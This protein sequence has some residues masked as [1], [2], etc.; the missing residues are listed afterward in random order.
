MTLSQLL[1]EL[2]HRGI[3]LN[4][5]GETLK[6]HGPKANLTPEL[7]N[8]LRQHKQTLLAHLQKSAPIDDALP[9]CKPD[10]E[11]LYKPFPL[12][13]LQQGF[14]VADDPH[15][16]FHVRPHYYME[17]DVEN[18]DVGRYEAAWNKLFQRHRLELAL[19]REDGNLEIIEN[20]E[21]LRVKAIDLRD[22]PL[23]E[24]TQFLAA[25]RAQ[26]MRSELPLDRWPWHDVRVTLWR[27]DDTDYGRIH[28]NHN[29]FFSDGY[30]TARALQEIEQYY[31]DP[32]AVLPPLSLSYRDAVIALDQLAES[33]QGLLA[34]RYWE[35][36]LPLLPGPP[37]LPFRPGMNRRCRS[38]L[39]RREK[40]MDAASWDS[41]KTYARKYGLTYSNAIFAAYAEILA[42]WSN[43]KHFVLSNMMTRRLNIHPEISDILGNFASL[44][45]L[46]I[47]LRT[48]AS[49]LE[50]AHQI[51][52]QVIQDSQHR[53]WGGMQVMQALN[54]LAGGFGRAPIPFVVGSGLFMEGFERYDFGCLETSQVMLDHQF[55]ELPD[56]SYFIVW[57][58]LE[59]FFSDG[60]VDAMWNAYLSLMNGLATDSTMWESKDFN[61]IPLSHLEERNRLN[62]SSH[63]ASSHRLHDFLYTHSNDNPERFAL[64]TS[65]DTLTYRQLHQRA[66]AITAALQA[67]GVCRQD[68]VAVIA[69]RNST[70][71]IALYGIL[72]AG[73]A[74]VPV[75]PSLPEERRQYL[76]NNSQAKLAITQSSYATSM[77][78]PDG[79]PILVADHIDEALAAPLNNDGATGNS[80]AEDLAYIIYTSGST[81]RPKG[82]MIDHR[83]IIN[84]IL[85]INQRFQVGSDDRFLGVSSFGF[86]L[87]VYDIFGAAAA[88]ATLLYPDPDKALNPA[89]WLDVL[90]AQQI[91]IWNSAPALASLLIEVAEYRGVQLESL[92]LVLLSGDWIPL[93][94][95]KRIRNVAPNAQVISLGG[96]TEASIWSIIYPVDH[97]DP[98]WVS[99]PYGYPMKNQSWFVMDEWNRPAPVWVQGDLYIGGTGLAKGYWNNP[100]KTAAAFITSPETGERLY[101]TGDIGRYLPDGSIELLGRKDSQIKIQ[102]HRIE[103]GEIESVLGSHPEIS[104]V[105]VIAQRA[106]TGKSMQL[107][108][109]IVRHADSTIDAETLRRYSANKLPDY[110]VPRLFHF[111]DKLPLNS[112]GKIDRQALS[113]IEESLTAD[114]SH[115]RYT[116]NNAVEAKL[117]EIW[118]R[119]L[120]AKDIS[121]TADFFRLGGQSFEAVRLIGLVK[122]TFGIGL[123]LGDIWRYPTIAQLAE[124]L[125]D[126]HQNTN[127]PLVAIN[128][129]NS[130]IPLFLVHPAAGHVMCYRYLGEQLNRPVY[131]FEALGIDGQHAPRSSVVEMATAYCASLKT[132]H[133]HGPI[134]IGGWSSGGPIAF[135]MA[136]QL[137]REGRTVE[138]IIIIDSPAP[139]IHDNA[140]DS[141]L[142]DWFLEDLMLDAE[143][144]AEIKTRTQHQS[145][146]EE[147]IK[148]LAQ[149]LAEYNTKLAADFDQLTMLYNVFIAVVR[150]NR[151]YRPNSI[152]VDMLIIRA[153]DG[154]VSEFAGYPYVD[155]MDWGWH[156]L[157]SG[158][159]SGEFLPGSHHT[160]LLPP[161]VNTISTMLET[162][163]PIV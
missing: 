62:Q 1:Q 48:G 10:A 162:Q 96:A 112:N 33:S 77:R 154:F 146:N 28:Y 16:E 111:I 126:D 65:A 144:I 151:T 42:A 38:R 55:F 54:R 118:Q 123:S 15:M 5:E 47:D 117:L 67:A 140:D 52:K 155:Q 41:F 20:P 105:A 84:T 132:A 64:V 114:I 90:K 76:L 63:E 80:E 102:G 127:T 109:H 89:H 131:A 57:D 58:L 149:A 36:R 59:E 46:E 158:K 122:E 13:D 92:R 40:I 21:P 161:I 138:K 72:N 74:C 108:A 100:E 66:L 24:V 157:T 14:Y 124:R 88:G 26:M 75:D 83:G 56:G 103:L 78:W 129:F 71:L 27:K 87:S 97:V 101:R 53:Q 68:N 116:P 79:L 94:L 50:R 147:R 163:L 143:I 70:L 43:S 99:I 120:T 9:L 91:S 39:Q 142:F 156:R 25:I 7:Q 51:Q 128:D 11:N 130:G 107:A 141:V 45:P 3:T 121:I 30:G 17:K 49:F 93:D 104:A 61:L 31:R 12:A 110:M 139:L 4:C 153:S 19:V 81:G 18:L 125:G 22:R 37:Q 159:I 133:P 113:F 106:T 29:N 148:E 95:P 23:D 86:D 85:D 82:V 35:D 150:A 44:Y 73:A 152:D 8:A 115:A 145:G 60:V 119:V 6:I 69:D 137:R 135:E 34:K 160:L 32:D 134:L 2:K 136:S 98:A